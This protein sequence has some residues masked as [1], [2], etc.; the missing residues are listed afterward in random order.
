MENASKA[1]I[2]IGSILVALMIVAASILIFNIA[3]NPISKTVDA[4]TTEERSFFNSKFKRY[5]SGRVTGLETKAFV[6]IVMQNANYQLNLEEKYRIPEIYISYKDKTK[7]SLERA[8]INSISDPDDFKSIFQKILNKVS[9]TAFYSI[10][11]ELNAKNGIV[12]KI[13][14]EE[15]NI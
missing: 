10:R 15:I 5:E 6:N 12:S 8:E 14:V 4:M 3:K 13:F 2:I 1:L 9:N 11:T 7:I